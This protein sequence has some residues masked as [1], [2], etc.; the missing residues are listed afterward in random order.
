MEAHVLVALRRRKDAAN[1]KLKSGCHKVIVRDDEEYAM[2]RLERLCDEGEWRIYRSVNKRNLHKAAQLLQVE[3]IYRADDIADRIDQVWK[4][5]LMKPECKSERKFLIDID[6][7]SVNTGY[8]K[9]RYLEGVTIY[10]TV[11]TPNGWH[12]VTGPFD[13]RKLLEDLG[14]VIEVK[15]DAL[16]YIKTIKG[17]M[18]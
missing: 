5:I 3:L 9:E 17:E 18:K 14:G 15:K 7:A 10:D 11:K 8:I 1:N 2:S 6:N 13:S 12:M 16:V 4:S